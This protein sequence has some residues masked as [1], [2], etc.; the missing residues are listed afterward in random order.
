[1]LKKP[2][3]EARLSDEMRLRALGK[4]L[5]AARE[6]RRMTVRQVSAAVGIPHPSIVAYEQGRTQPPALRLLTLARHLR[7]SGRVL[8]GLGR[9]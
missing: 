9:A 5:K 7:I 4:L 6:A 8:T 2:K 1:M 3:Q